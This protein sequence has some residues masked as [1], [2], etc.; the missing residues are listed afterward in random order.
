VRSARYKTLARAISCMRI[1]FTLNLTGERSFSRWIARSHSK[2]AQ[3]SSPPAEWR[4][5][6]SNDQQI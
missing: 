1:S 4:A 6:R 2:K 5:P 3:A